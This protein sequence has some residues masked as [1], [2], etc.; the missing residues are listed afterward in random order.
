MKISIKIEQVILYSIGL[1]ILGFVVGGIFDSR[2]ILMFGAIA[3]LPLCI[4]L[5]LAALASAWE[6]A[7]EIIPNFKG[8]SFLV[9]FVVLLVAIAFILV[10]FFGAGS[11]NSGCQ[12]YRGVPTC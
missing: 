11:E 6:A 9:V 8:K 3:L 12:S 2:L 10:I 5:F 1:G 4:I 7:D